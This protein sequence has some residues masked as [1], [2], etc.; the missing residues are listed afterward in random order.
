MFYSVPKFCTTLT[1]FASHRHNLARACR[2]KA[3]AGTVACLR[4]Y[5]PRSRWGMSGKHPFLFLLLLLQYKKVKKLE[6]MTPHSSLSASAFLNNLRKLE[7]RRNFAVFVFSTFD[8]YC[9]ATK[10]RRH[11][12]WG[13]KKEVC[14][15]RWFLLVSC[16]ILKEATS[17]VRHLLINLQYHIGCKF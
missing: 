14:R 2:K 7:A 6:T 5:Y 1:P 12:W 11:P 9:I 16:V 17:Q 3:I 8:K 13:D 15:T 4:D 10:A